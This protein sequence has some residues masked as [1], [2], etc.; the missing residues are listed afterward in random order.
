MEAVANYAHDPAGVIDN[1]TTQNAVFFSV[2][3]TVLHR[4]SPSSAF[5]VHKK[6]MSDFQDTKHR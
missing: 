1:G 4:K 6:S 2:N 5:I 3:D